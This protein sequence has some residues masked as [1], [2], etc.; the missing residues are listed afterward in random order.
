MHIHVYTTFMYTY[1]CIH[2]IKLC[3]H[4]RFFLQCVNEDCTWKLKCS[5]LHKSKIFKVRRFIAKHTCPAKDRLMSQRV[6][7]S[8]ILGR[9]IQYKYHDPKAVYNARDIITDMNKQFGLDLTYWKAHRAKLKA[10]KMVRG[11]PTESYAEIPRYL[12]MLTQSNPG[13]IVS[14]QKTVDGHFQYAFVALNSSIQGWVNCRPVVIVDGSF[15]KAA[16]HGTFLTASCQDAG[17]NRIDHRVKTYLYEIGYSKWS[18]AHSTSNRTMTMTSNIAESLNS[19]TKDARDLPVTRLLE[20]MRKLIEKWNYDKSKEALYTNTK[21]TA[22]YES[23]LADNLEIALH[24]MVRP[25]SDYL[26]TVTH[27][28]KTFIV[29]IKAKTCT[30]QQFQLDELPCPHALAVLHKKAWMEMI[31]AHHTIPRRT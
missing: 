23:I 22:K 14:L 18:R 17:V 15:L 27:M 3:I 7:T 9:A 24:M 6:A 21:L 8:T 31:T 26:H 29:C 25:S 5:A 20:E 1:P 11:D 13:S 28:G 30:C 4:F 10:L 16:Y 2:S 19:A 12:H